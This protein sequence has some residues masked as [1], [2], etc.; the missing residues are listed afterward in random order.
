[1]QRW[2]IGVSGFYPL[3]TSF[4]LLV[5]GSFTR[6]AGLSRMYGLELRY[7]FR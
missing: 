6:T 5:L 3:L 1:M 4:L 2:F 7:N